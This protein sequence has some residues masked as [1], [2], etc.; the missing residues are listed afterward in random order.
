MRI[1]WM[2]VFVFSD[3]V[4]LRGGAGGSGAHVGF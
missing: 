3:R 1:R 4:L 2:G